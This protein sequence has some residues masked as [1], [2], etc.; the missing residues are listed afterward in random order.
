MGTN[1][2]HSKKAAQAVLDSLKIADSK[3]NRQAAVISF[4]SLQ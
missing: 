3:G 4:V 1:K 2:N